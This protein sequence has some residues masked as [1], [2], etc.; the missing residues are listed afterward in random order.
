MILSSVTHDIM[1]G[2]YLF[3]STNQAWLGRAIKALME[4]V[5]Q[6]REGQKKPALQPF[7]KDTFPLLSPS[8]STG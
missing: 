2:E 8:T 4:S 7:I 6:V 5:F 1:N 3:S